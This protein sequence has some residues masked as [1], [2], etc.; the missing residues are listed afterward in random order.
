MEMGGWVEKRNS[1]YFFKRLLGRQEPADRHCV[2]V[3]FLAPAN[4]GWPTSPAKQ[5]RA[6]HEGGESPTLGRATS[7]HTRAVVSLCEGPQSC[8][9]RF[10]GLFWNLQRQD[11]G[12]LH[13]T[14]SDTS[15][16]SAKK[17]QEFSFG[18]VLPVLTRAY[19]CFV[20]RSK[21]FWDKQETGYAEL[22]VIKK[23]EI[24]GMG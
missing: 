12:N 22:Q 4:P 9:A 6:E 2:T 5:M 3:L 1:N 10:A 21:L 16:A 8:V 13:S 15:K 18:C 17:R 7:C 20:F 23:I 24:N 19:V 14:P 11:T